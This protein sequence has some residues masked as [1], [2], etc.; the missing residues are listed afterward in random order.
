MEGED[1]K[2]KSPA[3]RKQRRVKGLAIIKF[4]AKAQL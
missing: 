3:A 1:E 2:K 4:T